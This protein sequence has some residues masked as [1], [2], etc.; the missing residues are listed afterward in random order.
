MSS[1]KKF[2]NF[3]R[4]GLLSLCCQVAGLSQRPRTNDQRLPARSSSLSLGRTG[5]NSQ[6]FVFFHD[7][8]IFAIELNLGSGILAEQDPVALFY[9]QGEYLA[10]IVR[11][12]L[13]DGDDFALL[14]LVFGA[15][16]NDDSATSRFSFFHATHQDA[17]M[18]WGKLSHS[19][20]LLSFGLA[21]HFGLD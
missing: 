13:A 18:E 7:Q 2:L 6:N 20:K 17:V 11:A 1:P 16:R 4:A 14:R 15:I 21:L 9:C 19:C 8:E 10:F 5:E 3:C 12:A